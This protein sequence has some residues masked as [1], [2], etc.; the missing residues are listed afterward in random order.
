M[1]IK[2]IDIYYIRFTANSFVLHEKYFV[3]HDISSLSTVNERQ[4]CTSMHLL[5]LIYARIFLNKT[6]GVQVTTSILHHNS[7]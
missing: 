5:I 7:R 6:L 4:N 1:I 2:D 3:Q